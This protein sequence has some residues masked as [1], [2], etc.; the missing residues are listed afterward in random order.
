MI[1]LPVTVDSR[2]RQV[3][4]FPDHLCIRLRRSKQP[5][6][7]KVRTAVDKMPAGDYTV[8][9]FEDIVLV[10]TKRSALEIEENLLGKD[11][12]RA[13]SAFRRLC[14]ST[15]WPLLV[16]E[17][18]QADLDE[19]V[20]DALAWGIASYGL[21]V[22]FAGPR[23]ARRARRSTADMVLRLMIAMIDLEYPSL[24]RI[25]NGKGVPH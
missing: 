8:A 24:R 20:R 6:L 18:S 22:W 23:C 9:G 2:E 3:L 25:D 11:F 19:P 12:R 5:T 15:K 10:E 16:C 1:T 4:P 14:N 17:F 21:N 13:D 7:F